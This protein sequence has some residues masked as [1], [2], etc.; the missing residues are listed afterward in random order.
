MDTV[1]T[2]VRKTLDVLQQTGVFFD[3]LIKATEETLDGMQQE[4]IEVLLSLL[5][6]VRGNKKRSFSACCLGF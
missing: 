2:Q 1:S 3:P 4:V 6:E 5:C